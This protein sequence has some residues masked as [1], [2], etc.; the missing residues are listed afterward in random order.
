MSLK[1]R[2][3]E[4]SKNQK[5]MAALI[6]VVAFGVIAGVVIYCDIQFIQVM[7]RTYPDGIAKIFSLIGAVATGAS[8]LALIGAEAFWF[9]R[10]MQMVFGWIFT[11]LEAGIMACN[12]IL[13]FELTG[14]ITHLD[15]FMATYLWLCPA[16][17]VAAALCWIMIFNLDQ[18]QKARHDEREMQDDIAESDREHAKAVHRS[19]MALKQRYLESTTTYLD[20]IADDPNVQAGLR[21][22]AW[23]FAGEQLRELTGMYLALP[24]QPAAPDQP[25]MVDG[26]ISPATASGTANDDPKPDPAHEVPQSPVQQSRGWWPFGKKQEPQ[27]APAVP[28]LAEIVAALKAEMQP[29]EQAAPSA[30]ETSVPSQPAPKQTYPILPAAPRYIDTEP[31]PAKPNSYIDDL[32]DSV[33]GG[34]AGPLSQQS[35]HNQNGHQN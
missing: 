11:G 28:T 34:S 27:P 19:K 26:S 31:L 4:L 9:S 10:G 29:A 25:K 18:G 13:G 14:G 15:Q 32:V 30:P 20:Q 22:G 6:K 12:V 24:A 16:T 35:A 1:Q 21:L 7:W 17:P 3:A 2:T 5:A 23:K 33:G 8:V